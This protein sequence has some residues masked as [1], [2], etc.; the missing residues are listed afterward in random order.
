MTRGLATA[1][2]VC[3]LAL[4]LAG[5]LACGK[6]GEPRPPLR[7]TPAAITGLRLSQRGDQVEI[8]FTAPRTSTD[9]ARLPV[10]EIELFVT[11]QEGDFAKLARTRRFKAAPGE[12][13]TETEPLPAPGTTLRV[14]A[15]ALAKRH[16]GSLPEPARLVVLAPLVAPL[17]LGAGLVG[18]GVS[19][20][21]QGDIPAPLPT[22]APSPTPAPAA[23]PGPEP[24]AVTAPAPTTADQVTVATA[25]S[26]A[27]LPTAGALPRAPGTPA[28]PGPTPTPT[29]KPTPPPFTPGFFIYKRPSAGTYAAPL[30]PAATAERTFVDKTAE[31]GESSCYAIRAVAS[32]DP[33]VESGASNEA[34]IEVKDV[35]APAAPAGVAALPREDGIEVSWSPSPEADLAF[36]RVYRTARQ[37]GGT[38]RVAEVPATETAFLDKEA[39]AG[40]LRY[41][42][43][44][45]D[46]SG[47]ESPKS[48]STEA[49]RP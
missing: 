1:A 37:G 42:V 12:A 28:A 19:L 41:N 14:A 35:L 5:G 13:L 16:R 24:S 38:E 25:S 4:L 15:R 8:R 18:E 36:Y 30:S 39:P 20:E 11:D 9:G 31:P 3:G 29:P 21:W 23:P 26:A 32:A 44:A 17:G 45:V 43:T 48:P 34:C 33:L 46:V 40:P 6:K 47:N 7:P 22:E 27:P 10:L 49:R 2:T